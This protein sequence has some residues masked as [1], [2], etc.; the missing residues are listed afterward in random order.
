[1]HILFL[2]MVDTIFF[3]QLNSPS[4]KHAI[5]IVQ[6]LW[7]IML[8]DLSVVR[9]LDSA[10]D[11]HQL[12]TWVHTHLLNRCEK[13]HKT[14]FGI[15]PWFSKKTSN[16]QNTALQTVIFFL[17]EL[18]MKTVDSLMFL[19]GPEPMVLWFWFVQKK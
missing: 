18:F 2:D 10:T 1:M 12:S 3:P 13:T 6:I 19:K 16:I 7:K 5:L 8:F 9:V 17:V 15:E 4:L 14:S 11:T